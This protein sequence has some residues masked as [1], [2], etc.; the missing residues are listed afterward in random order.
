MELGVNAKGEMT[1]FAAA[2][3]DAQ[4]GTFKTGFYTKFDG[5]GIN[6]IGYKTQAKV[7]AGVGV[8]TN[9][10]VGE[11]TQFS[12]VPSPAEPRTGVLKEYGAK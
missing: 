2:K 7:S 10:L 3:G 5:N 4:V 1:F 6:D 11:S 8:K 12:L 9:Y